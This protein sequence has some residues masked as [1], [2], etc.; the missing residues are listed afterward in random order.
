[1]NSVGKGIGI[2]GLIVSL[3]AIPV[4]VFGIWI[5]IAALVLV[6]VGAL[7][8]DKTFTI[9]TVVISATN[10]L[11]FSPLIL[12]AIFGSPDQEGSSFLATVVIVSLLLP[13]MAMILQ[14]TGKVVLGKR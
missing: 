6:S 8:G 3:I 1:M 4:P 5:M 2:A 12:V 7:F 13:I 9:A 14:A 10:T 11:L